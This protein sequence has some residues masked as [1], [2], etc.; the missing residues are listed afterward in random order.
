MEQGVSSLMAL[1]NVPTPRRRT[2]P[3][4]LRLLP[5]HLLPVQQDL[6]GTRLSS[7]SL[8]FLSTAPTNVGFWICRTPSV[9]CRITIPSGWLLRTLRL[10]LPLR[11]IA[12]RIAL[13]PMRVI[14]AAELHLTHHHVRHTHPRRNTLFAAQMLPSITRRPASNLEAT[15]SF[16]QYT[17][18]LLSRHHHRS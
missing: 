1:S 6:Y 11:T 7:T 13:C 2:L 17:I 18:S 4:S 5:L 10:C 16:S 8:P 12:S 15:R 14:R 9:H 3:R